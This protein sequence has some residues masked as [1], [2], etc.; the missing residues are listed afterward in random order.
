MRD[1]AIEKFNREMQGRPNDPYVEIIGHYVIDRCTDDITAAKMLK[2]GKTLAGAMEK[3][4]AEARAEVKRNKNGNVAVLTPE[5][6]FGAVDGYFGLETD[7]AAQQKALGGTAD[8]A[9][10]ASAAQAPTQEAGRGR[11]ALDV[12]DFL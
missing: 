11:L 8:Q 4:L 6:V 7:R 12:V 1:K 3:V 9:A 10:Q 5:R 2:D